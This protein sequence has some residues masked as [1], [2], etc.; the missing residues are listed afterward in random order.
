MGAFQVGLRPR[1]AMRIA[2]I[3][4][5]NAT[6]IENAADGVRGVLRSDP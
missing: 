3:R 4:T 5:A 1:A 6:G 2:L